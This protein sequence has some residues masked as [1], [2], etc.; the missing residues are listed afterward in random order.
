MHAASKE[1]T[2]PKVITYGTF[3]TLHFGHISLLQRAKSFGVHLTVALSTD[4]F[5]AEK[6]KK[7]HFSYEERKGFLEA[8]RYVDIVIPEQTWG[9]KNDDI[10]NNDIDIF[11]M[12]SDWDGH[13]DELR[14]I[15][16]VHYLER[17]PAISSTLIKANM[18]HLDV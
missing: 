9:Q 2:V 17:T 6:G 15:C 12:G 10:I 5:H 7:S 4:E 18:R 3:D 8:I 11:V 14:T 13:F 16:K 1:R